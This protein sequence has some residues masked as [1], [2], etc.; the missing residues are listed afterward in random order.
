M[1]VIA[2]LGLG[3]VGFMIG[4]L[5]FLSGARWVLAI[6]AA[7]KSADA[8][9]AAIASATLLHAGPWVIVAV[10]IFA[11]YI[12][13]EPWARPIYVGAVT[14]ALFFGV[15]AIIVQ[16]KLKLRGRDAT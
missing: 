14:A 5:L 7:K 11:A 2:N 12:R 13:S 9:R 1:S 16:R 4:N 10:G 3:M 8:P 6:A 15:I